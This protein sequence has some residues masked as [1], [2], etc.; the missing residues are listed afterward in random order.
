MHMISKTGPECEL[1]HFESEEC[2]S[3]NRRILRIPANILIP[4]RAAFL[5]PVVTSLEE[6]LQA[7]DLGFVEVGIPDFENQHDTVAVTPIPGLMLEAVVK[8]ED[9]AL[10]PGTDLIA[11][12]D[13]APV[14][15]DQ[16]QMGRQTN[17]HLAVM[18]NYMRVGLQN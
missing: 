3:R 1:R 11:G 10:R 16:T 15:N 5:Q 4:S 2:N 7:F 6:V 18:R 13:A 17:V 14:G 9:L 8:H 12:P